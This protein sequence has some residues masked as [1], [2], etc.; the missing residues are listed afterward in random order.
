MNHQPDQSQRI[1]PL[2]TTHLSG[3]AVGPVRPR[4]DELL[5]QRLLPQPE[6]LQLDR[7]RLAESVVRLQRRRR[8]R[9]LVMQD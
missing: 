7:V 3:L 4:G 1:A 2:F 6:Q 5:V 9:E 8:N